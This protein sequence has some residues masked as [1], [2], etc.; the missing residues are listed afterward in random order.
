MMQIFTYDFM[1]LSG[2]IFGMGMSH[3]NRKRIEEAITRKCIETG[4]TWFDYGNAYY[5]AKHGDIQIR[6][7]SAALLSTE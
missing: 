6:R 1:S 2:V 4:R 3:D 5:S 7:Y